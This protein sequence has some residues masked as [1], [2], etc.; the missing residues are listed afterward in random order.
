MRDI[1]VSG[2]PDLS[3][4]SDCVIGYQ[5]RDSGGLEIAVESKVA[6][7]YGEAIRGLAEQT[8][9]ELGIANGS[10]SIE[11]FGAVPFVQQAR[12]EAAVKMAHPELDA[13]TMPELD[14][15][16]QSPAGR[17][18]F[19]R[20]RLYLPG[21]QPKL[22]LN[23]GIHQPD[24]IILDLEDSVG[25]GEKLSARFI[26]RNALRV[27]DFFGAERMVRINQGELGREDLASIIPQPVD[28]VL[29]PKVETTD[30]VE[31]VDADI[32]RICQAVGRKEPVFI[33]PIIESA[34]GVLNA[35]E[36]A[37]ASPHNVA[38]TIGLED[39]AADLGVE[40]TAGGGESRFAR[41]M[42][43]NAARAAG[44]QAIGSVFGDVADEDGLRAAAEEAKGMGFDG[45]GAIHP[46]QIAVI[47]EAFAPTDT[48]IENAKAIVRAYDEA[49]AQ[50]LGVV[51]LGSKMIDPPVVQRAQRT[52]DLAVAVGKLAEGWKDEPE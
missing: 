11:D 22:M 14:P 23:A 17:D 32:A 16:G 24:A 49:E 1:F 40:R 4:R 41:D 5:P 46:R 45:M 31:A 7:M 18:R 19:R 34:R 8:L 48:E 35:G 36:I 13:T 37:L 3:P 27:L 2:T 25:A 12:I 6:V 44:L 42:V 38:L 29:I 33:M 47:H 50:G 21:S 20:S 30:Q 9:G 10:L 43:V 28:L 26:V 39:Y 15:H 51:S 52:V